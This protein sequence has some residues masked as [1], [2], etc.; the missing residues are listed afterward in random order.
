[1][2]DVKTKQKSNANATPSKKT[3]SLKVA[4]TPKKVTEQ[5]E[6][7]KQETKALIESFKPTAEQRIQNAR[8]FEILTTKY[9]HLKE[10]KEELEQFKISSDGT[11]ERIYFENSE[12]FK[13]EVSNSKIIDD[14]LKLAD[15]TLNNILTE[16]EKQVQDFVI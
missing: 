3:T 7:V 5:K 16:T 13:L 10:K 12:G 11:S 4:T 14:M 2:N 6:Q 1:M 15:N 9:R 8:K